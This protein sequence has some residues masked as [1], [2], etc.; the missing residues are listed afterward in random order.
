VT[1]ADE[2]VER[3]SRQILLPEVGGR[4]QERLCA[5]RVEVAGQGDAADVAADLL[6]AAGVQVERPTGRAGDLVIAFDERRAIVARSGATSATVAIAVG[7]PCRHCVDRVLPTPIDSTVASG[8]TAQIVG[9]LA[10]AEALR[11][12]L[13]LAS[14]SRT[15]TLDLS[16]GRFAAHPLATPACDSCAGDA[17]GEPHP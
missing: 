9:A 5:T 17:E 7:R 2:L 4:G 1:L 3:Y 10:A 14:A 6:A 16:A 11:V 15:H 8:T 12:A 13:D